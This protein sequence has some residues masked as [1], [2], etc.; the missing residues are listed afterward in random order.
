M[1]IAILYPIP[2]SEKRSPGVLTKP[3][4]IPSGEED[5]WVSFIKGEKEALESNWYC[6]KQPSSTDIKKGITWSEARRHENNFFSTT[7]PW[8]GLDSIYQKYLRTSN[9]VERLS[10]ILS[11]LISKR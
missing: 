2:E 5:G 1:H 10:H 9:L 11:D 4:R 7:S 3:D 6:V 8:S